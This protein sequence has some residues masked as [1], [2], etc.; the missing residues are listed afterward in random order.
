MSKEILI[1]IRDK[2]ADRISGEYVCGNSDFV[3]VFD[4][5]EEWNAYETK[6]ARFYYGD[7][8]IDK[9]FNGDRC[10]IPI[11][12]NI[13][14]FEVGVFAG[15]L[16]TST[17]AYVPARKSILCKGGSPAAPSPDVYAQI[18][19]MLNEA[20]F[21]PEEIAAAVK[22]YLDG[23]GIDLGDEYT[24]VTEEYIKHGGDPINFFHKLGE[25]KYI[26]DDGYRVYRCENIEYGGCLYT[27]VKSYGD[28]QLFTEEFF[29]DGVKVYEK[30]SLI[31]DEEYYT[32]LGNICVPRT[33]NGAANK[34]YVDDTAK[35]IEEK[36]PKNASNIG[37]DMTI[38]EQK[39]ENVGDALNALANRSVG[40]SSDEWEFIGEFTLPED[41]LDW[42]IT[43]D[44]DG[45]PIE[46]KKMFVYMI[47]EP[48]AITAGNNNAIF[49]N[50]AVSGPF[51]TNCYYAKY[52]CI[53]S[54]KTKQTFLA[55]YIP[56]W[57]NGNGSAVLALT[58]AGTLNTSW[59]LGDNSAGRSILKNCI[60]GLT[61]KVEK[62]ET[63]IG[64]NSVIKI[65]GVR[66]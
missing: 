64:A 55:E 18:M 8:Y 29:I 22:K 21:P 47:S 48:S 36:I 40:G 1:K 3:A 49:G 4:F 28:D 20:K 61:M 63:A 23:N 42:E 34:K 62:T 35:G 31:C 26:V 30:E 50:P 10:E 17:S 5:D 44:A 51:T 9:P 54:V 38:D 39:C 37:C 24:D 19:E 15:N 32:R 58:S 53:R 11:L 60:G 45:K 46:L 41:S 25:G 27:E 66:M 56:V 7:D 43:E 16:K 14:S 59:S 12:S 65:W 52:N 33:D 6:T 13:H 57:G 2:I